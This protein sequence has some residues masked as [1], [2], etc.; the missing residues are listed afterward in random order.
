MGAYR[1]LIALLPLLELGHRT[2]NAL[3]NDLHA[4]VNAAVLDVRCMHQCFLTCTM[5]AISPPRIWCA[6]A[7]FHS[8]IME[9]MF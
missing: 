2:D 9:Y 7:A 4:A 5:P 1:R 3:P 8:L 6:S